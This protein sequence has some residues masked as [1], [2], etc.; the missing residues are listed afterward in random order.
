MKKTVLRLWSLIL[1]MLLLC[2][3]SAADTPNGTNAPEP[4]LGNGFPGLGGTMPEMTFDMGDGETVTLSRLLEEKELV[5]LNFWFED[6][7]WCVKE[8][9]VIELVYQQYKQD[10]EIVALNP[11]DGTDAVKK[12]KTDHSLSFPMVSCPRAWAVEAGISGYPTSVFIDRDGVICLIQP[13]AITSQA[14]WLELFDAFT[15][16]DYHRKIYRS[17]QDVLL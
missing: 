2:G 4:E 15:G 6:C 9:P 10:V 1:A 8:F 3:C 13:G 7:P 12:F 17:V 5:V 16:E 11:V 14:A